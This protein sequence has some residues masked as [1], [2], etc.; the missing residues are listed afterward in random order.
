MAMLRK[1]LLLLVLVALV[2][3]GGVALG[4]WTGDH[5]TREAR[6]A[7]LARR[8]GPRHGVRRRPPAPPLPLAHATTSL[9]SIE[10]AGLRREWLQTVPARPVSPS[11]P[12]L[13]V[14]HGRFTT[15][16]EEAQRDG[17]LPLASQGD[18]SLVYPAGI[19]N[20]WNAGGCCG[21][22][23]RQHV[24]DIGFLKALVAHLDP[25][26]RRPAY[27]VGFSNGGRLAYTVACEDPGLVDGYAVVDA[28]SVR[29]CPASHP[30]SL[31]QVDGTAD[32]L[33]AYQTGDRGVERIP[34]TTQVAEM[35]ALDGCPVRAVTT[36]RGRLELAT[37]DGCRGGT[38][39]QFATYRDEPHEW[40]EPDATT[41]GA[42]SVIWSL[43][44]RSASA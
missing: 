35:R 11:I 18:A 42:A 2:A 34:A 44:T 22:A 7:P 9:E 20:S 19:G 17:L 30:V 32:P 27:L 13:I 41:P 23:A 21:L 15:P 33:V 40:P 26:E 24:D 14:L 36:R 29:A 31:V 4:R 25:G 28:V 37:W 8:L 3:A 10:V 1:R 5:P 38:R 16:Q 43:L 12:L 6:A 39:L